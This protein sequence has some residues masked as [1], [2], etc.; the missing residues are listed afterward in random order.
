MKKRL[1]PEEEKFF[2][3][4]IKNPTWSSFTCFL[5]LIRKKKYSPE[6]VRELFEKMVE[7]NDY[8]RTDKN[9]VIDYCIEETMN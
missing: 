3:I 2:L 9:Q 8:A 6:T 7:K 4:Q 5:G 1:T